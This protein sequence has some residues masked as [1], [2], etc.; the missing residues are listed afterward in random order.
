MPST[1]SPPR[2]SR[3]CRVTQMLLLHWVQLQTGMTPQGCEAPDQHQSMLLKSSAWMTA[4]LSCSAFILKQ[5]W[6]SSSLT[7]KNCSELHSKLAALSNLKSAAAKTEDPSTEMHMQSNE[8]FPEGKHHEGHQTSIL[9]CQVFA[10]ALKN[11]TLSTK[12]KKK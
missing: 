11:R 6:I 7:A 1:V 5:S 3:A 4:N 2:H 9:W 10:V 12:K 8:A